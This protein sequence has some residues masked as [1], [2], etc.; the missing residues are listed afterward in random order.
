MYVTEFT[1]HAKPGHYEELAEI[2]SQFAADFLSDHPALQTVLVVGD[3]AS[4]M[5]R[6]IGVYT[7]REA[8]DEVN[9]DPEFASYNDQIEPL[10]ADPPERVEVRLLHLYSR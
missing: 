9:S 6:G 5:V 4:G 3:E 2:H 10:L 8:A 7:D 1:L